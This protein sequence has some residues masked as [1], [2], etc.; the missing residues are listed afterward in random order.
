MAEGVFIKHF[1]AL[2]PDDEMAESIMQTI[3]VGEAVKVK[4]TRSRS[5]P[6]L[7]LYWKLMQVVFENQE[8]YQTKEDLEEDVR[9]AIGHSRTVPTF[10][11]GERVKARP[12][13][14]AQMDQ[15]EFNIFFTKA[16]NFICSKII[17]GMNTD[18]LKREVYELLGDGQ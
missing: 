12:I 4:V 17:P 3:K 15:A 5:L 18:D 10:R 13:N 11:G 9:I 7:R 6:H 2:R 1:S 14:F 16:T 8:I